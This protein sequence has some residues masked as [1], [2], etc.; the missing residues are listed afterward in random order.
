MANP[1][2]PDPGPELPPREGHGNLELHAILFYRADGQ[3]V[4]VVALIP[5]YL[6][7]LGING[8]HEIALLVQ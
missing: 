7:A 5:G 3:L 4:A 6:L 8:L 2:L 1:R